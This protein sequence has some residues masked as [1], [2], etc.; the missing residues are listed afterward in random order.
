MCE[1]KILVFQISKDL[2]IR[3]FCEM[4]NNVR[5][6]LLIYDSILYLSALI[7]YSK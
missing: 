3:E 5:E 2:I 4:C 6:T 1:V 7:L